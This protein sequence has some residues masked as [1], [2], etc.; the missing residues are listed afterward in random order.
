MK[1]LPPFTTAELH[2]TTVRLTGDGIQCDI[3][4]PKLFSDICEGEGYY[5]A[6][7]CNVVI[8]P[9]VNA[10]IDPARAEAY[11]DWRN[12]TAVTYAEYISQYLQT[13]L[14]WGNALAW[15]SDAEVQKTN[16]TNFQTEAD[17][18]YF[19]RRRK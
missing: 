19:A 17:D 8:L 10:E 18:A 14:D 12:G 5:H 4:A 3:N 6:P 9:P 11:T 2:G 7:H 13:V 15:L 16:E 1:D